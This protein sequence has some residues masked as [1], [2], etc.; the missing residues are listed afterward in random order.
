MV[1]YSSNMKDDHRVN[2]LNGRSGLAKRPQSNPGSFPKAELTVIKLVGAST[3]STK[4][5]MAGNVRNP[6]TSPAK[7]PCKEFEGETMGR[8]ADSS[9]CWLVRSSHYQRKSSGSACMEDR[10]KMPDPSGQERR[11][12]RGGGRQPAG[13]KCDNKQ[14][15]GGPV[16]VPVQ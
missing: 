3:Y 1:R 15:V 12:A 13:Q 11:L 8:H 14:I 5:R 9:G 16:W 6:K 7:G 4:N 10:A 2:E